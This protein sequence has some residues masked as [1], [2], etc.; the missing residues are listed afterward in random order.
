ME[1]KGG[2]VKWF[3][4]TTSKVRNDE[5]VEDDKKSKEARK[6]FQR[7]LVMQYELEKN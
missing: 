1:E 3:S 4:E 5:Y 6:V 2:F 7:R